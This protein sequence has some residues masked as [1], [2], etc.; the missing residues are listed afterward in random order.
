VVPEEVGH[1]DHHGGKFVTAWQHSETAAV[2]WLHVVLTQITAVMAPRGC[3]STSM[4][5]GMV[6]CVACVVRGCGEERGRVDEGNKLGQR[7]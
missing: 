2:Y 6:V 3:W 4:V 5:A 1:C 7:C